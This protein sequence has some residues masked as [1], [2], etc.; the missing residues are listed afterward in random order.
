MAVTY[1]P[2]RHEFALFA[3]RYY[4]NYGIRATSRTE[5]SHAELK[6]HLKNRVADL[7]G[8]F[9]AIK[10]MTDKRTERF[11]TQLAKEKAERLPKFTRIALFTPLCLHVSFQ[12]LD[13]IHQQYLQASDYHKGILPR[14]KLPACTRSFRKQYGLPCRHEILER[15]DA[16]APLRIEDCDRHWWIRSTDTDSELLRRF[17]EPDPNVVPPRGRPRNGPVTFQNNRT[18]N[19][20][21]RDFSHDEIHGQDGRIGSHGNI[22]R[23]RRGARGGTGGRRNGRNT[24][25]RRVANMEATLQRLA[26]V[27]EG[28]ERRQ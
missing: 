19:T 12:A 17:Q 20:T 6:R 11:D 1:I 28:G 13:L 7:H 23:P 24:V 5:G 15:L 4:K 2:W 21:R 27:L 9:S 18:D 10:T 8:L 26:E 16:V 22:Q 3:T 25:T 14:Q